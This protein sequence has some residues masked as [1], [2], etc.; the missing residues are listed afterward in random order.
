MPLPAIGDAVAFA[1]AS[2]VA[3]ESRYA[4]QVLVGV[5]RVRGTWR[6]G[7][8]AV[9]VL[10]WYAPVERD[11]TG[12]FDLSHVEE[13]TDSLVD[14]YD[15]SVEMTF[16]MIDRRGSD[17]VKLT[18]EE[19]RFCL[20]VLATD[21]QRATTAIGRP[22]SLQPL[23]RRR[24]VAVMPR[25]SASWI[26]EP[27]AP[28]PCLPGPA[29][30][31]LRHAISCRKV[32]IELV[33]RGRYRAKHVRMEYSWWRR[34]QT[35][36]GRN[37]ERKPHSSP[38]LKGIGDAPVGDGAAET[39]RNASLSP[40]ERSEKALR[41]GTHRVDPGTRRVG[42]N[43][44]GPGE[45]QGTSTRVSRRVVQR[46]RRRR[47]RLLFAAETADIPDSSLPPT[48]TPSD[49]S[50]TAALPLAPLAPG[51]VDLRAFRA[52]AAEVKTLSTPRWHRIRAPPLSPEEIIDL[53]E[54][55]LSV[56]DRTDRDPP[57]TGGP[58]RSTLTREDVFHQ[59]LDMISWN[60]LAVRGI[61]KSERPKKPDG[62]FFVRPKSDKKKSRPLYDGSPG[63]EPAP[64]FALPSMDLIID[65]AMRQ[66]SELHELGE[67]AGAASIDQRSW[68]PQIPI[69]EAVGRRLM[70]GLTHKLRRR[71]ARHFGIPM[72]DLC[73]IHLVLAQGWSWAPIAAQTLSEVLLAGLDPAGCIYDNYLLVDSMKQPTKVSTFLARTARTK[74]ELNTEKSQMELQPLVSFCGGELDL[75]RLRHRCDS[76]WAEKLSA[77]LDSV[78][79]SRDVSY[80]TAY[81]L[82]S[83]S[84]YFLRLTGEKLCQHRPL[85]SAMR[86]IGRRVYR[87]ASWE[88]PW[89]ISPGL[90]AALRA[91][92]L[93]AAKND[94]K[95]WVPPPPEIRAAANTQRR[96][97]GDGPVRHRRKEE[98][99]LGGAQPVHPQ[100][101]A[102]PTADRSMAR[103][104]PE[105][106][107]I[108]PGSG[109]RVRAALR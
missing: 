44:C 62:A 56:L 16:G 43:D 96:L 3:W 35:W 30:S 5:G 59:L 87:G 107:P 72:D 42:T 9:D 46:V 36:V 18:S 90:R 4:A 105:H 99:R 109:G 26:I 106:R 80:R 86:V 85:L 32:E 45:G 6:S 41:L 77:A 74:C 27:P 15:I 98:R 54:G 23:H 11:H 100:P 34:A 69:A 92:G 102:M 82:I 89:Q 101:R 94:W 66:A 2:S 12:P 51:T 17:W 21:F 76:A 20:A 91:I 108:R 64:R 48:R 79:D 81:K 28:T 22:P 88:T 78:S 33:R 63:N 10:R 40:S 58:K 71:L 7:A 29:A 84:L 53:L 57:G 24:A 1:A 52:L 38:V 49:P 103:V 39:R 73:I 25:N 75:D 60:K 55:D 93:A 67:R 97:R 61:P 19:L 50:V 14:H 68:Y 47:A 104:G 31:H 13:L 83:S 37:R 95:Q 8:I 70:I 65:T